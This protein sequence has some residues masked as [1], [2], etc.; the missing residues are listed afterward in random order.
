[1]A[2]VPAADGVAIVVCNSC[3]YSPEQRLGAEGS[4]GGAQLLDRLRAVHAGCERYHGVHIQEM[5]CLFACKDHI[6]LH[7]RA[8]GKISYILGNFAPTDEAAR[9]ILDFTVLY[10]ASADGQVAYREW[11]EGIKGH[12]LTRMP[13]QGFLIA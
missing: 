7:L 9:A 4:S 3:R 1:M 10:A 5:G 13:P 2:L 8:P 6:S 12:F 11:P